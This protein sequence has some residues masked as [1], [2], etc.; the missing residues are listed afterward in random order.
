M[1]QQKTAVIKKKKALI[2]NGS[3]FSLKDYEAGNTKIR[4][5]KR[6]VLDKTMYGKIRILKTYIKKTHTNKKGNV[7]CKISLKT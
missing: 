7:K 3:S 4:Q 5:I 6:Q 1:R 2:R